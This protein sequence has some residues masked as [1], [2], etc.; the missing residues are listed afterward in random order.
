M[1]RPTPTPATPPTPCI[2]PR[3]RA[4]LDVPL[5]SDL[6]WRSLALSS[7]LGPYPTPAGT[8]VQRKSEQPGAFHAVDRLRVGEA[9]AVPGLQLVDQPFAGER[10]LGEVLLRRPDGL[11]IPVHREIGSAH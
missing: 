6:P 3:Q 9:V 7:R 5:G 4:F 1:A 8:A 2:R 11:L 10:P